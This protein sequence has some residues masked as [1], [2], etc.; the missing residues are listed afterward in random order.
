[1]EYPSYELLFC[2]EDK[3]DPA[4]L[5]VRQLMERYPKVEAR[6][7]LGGSDVGVNPKINNMNPGYE[8]AKFEYIMISDS[9]IR[10]KED[11]LL[12]MVEHM[13]DDVAL[14]HQMPFTCDREGFSATYEKVSDPPPTVKIHIFFGIKIL[15]PK[16]S[17]RKSLQKGLA[18]R[19]LKTLAL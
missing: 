6:L 13:T 5:I 14:V 16:K 15:K 4:I 12:D 19:K 7:F 17:P 8:A 11:T 10:M 9:G 18:K 3:E 2:V 1:M